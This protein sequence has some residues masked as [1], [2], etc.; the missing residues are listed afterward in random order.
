MNWCKNSPRVASNHVIFVEKPIS[1]FLCHFVKCN[2]L[3]RL[4]GS[5]QG[6]NTWPAI[7]R[8]SVGWSFAISRE[9]LARVYPLPLSFSNLSQSISKTYFYVYDIDLITFLICLTVHHW[10]W[11]CIIFFWECTTAPPPPIPET[12]SMSQRQH[13][14][15]KSFIRFWPTYKD[16]S[17]YQNQPG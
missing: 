11:N 13:P 6:A 3:V 12:V 14:Y 8:S 4:F 17:H 9:W 1:R 15:I 10:K 5:I 16:S 7:F 2:W